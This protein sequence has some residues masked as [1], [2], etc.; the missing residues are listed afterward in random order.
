MITNITIC[1]KTVTITNG[2]TVG[3]QQAQENQHDCSK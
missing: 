2:L 1:A 3:A